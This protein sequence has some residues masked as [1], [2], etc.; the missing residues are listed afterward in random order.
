MA[1]FLYSLYTTPLLSVASNHHSMQ[2]IHKFIYRFLLSLHTSSAFSTIESCIRDVFSWISNKFSVNPNKAEYLLFTPNNVNLP[3]DINNCGSNT[4]SPSDG[5][6]N[7]GAIF[8]TDMS[9]DKYISFIII[10][11]FLQLRDFHHIR[12]F[13]SK[14]AT[15]TLANAFVHSHLDFCNS[16]FYGLPKYSIHRLQKVQNTVAHIVKNSSHFSLI[17]PTFI[18][19]LY[20]T[21][22]ISNMLHY[23]P[24]SF[25]R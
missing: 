18:G 2:M 4:I 3:V 21:V 5:A 20:F 11:C 19:F 16:L 14:T 15:I 8:Q 10:S 17:T 23:A 24:C 13:I 6:K 7:L 25:L 1:A 22:L 12:P 9:M